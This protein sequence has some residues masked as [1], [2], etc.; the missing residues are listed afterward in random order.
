[1]ES[2]LDRQMLDLFQTMR[3]EDEG[4]RRWVVEVLRAKSTT[5]EQDATAER[6]ELQREL[7]A[8]RKQKDRLLSLRLLDEIES[9]TFAAKQSKK[10]KLQTRLEGTA[11]QQ[12]E[13]GD[14]AVK[15]FE[16]SQALGAKWLA[17]DIA[18]KRLLLEIVCLNLKLVDVTLVPEMRKPFD[19][20]AEGLLI[21][22]SRGDW[23]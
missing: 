14:W 20:L 9:E 23:I 6:D 5:A 21:S 13:R 17:A 2:K 16:L 8:V 19:M 22:S 10:T 4:V 1:M 15:V 11:R 7:D 18:E 3:I 12:S